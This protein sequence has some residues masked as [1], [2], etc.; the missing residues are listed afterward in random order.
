VPALRKLRADRRGIAVWSITSIEE[1]QAREEGGCGCAGGDQQL[2]SAGIDFFWL[3][4]A[5]PRGICLLA[6]GQARRPPRWARL[7]R[8]IYRGKKQRRNPK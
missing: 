3:C 2:G 4:L 1:D 5:R 8:P 7:F 6:P